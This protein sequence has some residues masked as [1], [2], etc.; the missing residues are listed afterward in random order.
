MLIQ[1]DKPQV[2]AGFESITLYTGTEGT[3]KGLTVP[4][5]ARFAKIKVVDQTIRYR[6]DGTDPTSTVGYSVAANGEVDVY[7][8]EQLE[9]FKAV[10][11]DTAGGLEI[12][13]YKVQ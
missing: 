4:S 11:K 10:S 8:R 7:S 6:D 5:G 12:L 3:P 2:P 1:Y 9:N 13:Y